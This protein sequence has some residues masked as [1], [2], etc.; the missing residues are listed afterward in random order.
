M[1][2]QPIVLAG[3]S[4][5][6]LWPLSREMYPK[7]L[8]CLTGDHSLL[9]TTMLRIA[10]LPDAFKPLVVV[11]EEHRFTTQAQMDELTAC[12]EY[13]LLLEP[14]GRDTA[15]A[16]CAAALFAAEKLDKNENTP[17]LVLPADHLIKDEEAFRRAVA[18]ATVLAEAGH[19]VTFGIKPDYPE[20][21]FGYIEQGDGL[22]VAS[23]R[24]KPD[25]AT[26]E[27]YLQ[28][29]NYLWNAGMFLFTIATLR[30][31]LEAHAPEVLAAMGRALQRGSGDAHIFHLGREAMRLAPAISFD[32]A[33]MEKT[34]RAAVVPVELGW[35]DIGS[36]QALWRV[37]EK[38]ADG[39]ITQGDVWL[40]DSKNCL[41]RAEGRFVA[42]AGLRDT[43]VVET[44]DS[45]LVASLA[46]SQK[47][48]Q[49]VNFLKKEK[50]KESLTHVTVH[51]PWGSYT[52][53]EE[54][55]RFQIKRITVK[56]QAKLSLQLHYH[57]YEHWVVVRGTAQ[58][59]NGDKAI[60]LREN[61]STFIPA[62]QQHRLENPG[63]INL[64]IIE[65]QIGP[66]LG[67]DDIVRFDD[68]FG[69]CEG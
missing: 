47:V 45:L 6:R 35:S 3:G 27:N 28:S 18:Q 24:E 51:R 64:E 59:T 67:E 60:L 17:L 57:R 40:D 14:M 37:L 39:N 55:A 42:V 68:D 26:A 50:R 41:V 10:G 66:Y 15:A 30:A 9:Q 29:G 32:Y 48:K 33:V 2:I 65:V 12:A 34:N 61:E 31:E 25:Q 52:V 58:V 11:G 63:S 19:L 46:Q 53:L 23:F 56:P 36:W 43:V 4:G 16:V 54:Q 49:I 38:D 13:S 22:K 44:A 1:P 8:L 5:S 62:G 7:Q 69:R 21:G 20:T